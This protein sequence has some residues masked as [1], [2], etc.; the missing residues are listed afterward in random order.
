M[1]KS[2]SSVFTTTSDVSVPKERVPVGKG[3]IES[4]YYPAKVEYAYL[5]ESSAG[6]VGVVVSLKLDVQGT[7]VTKSETFW[8]TNR[9]KENFYKDKEGKKVVMPSFQT[10]TDIYGLVNNT[11]IEN[12]EADIDS[13]VIKVYDYDSKTEVPT[14]V[15]MITTLLNADIG[16]LMQKVTKNKSAKQANGSYADTA[17]F[18]TTNQI[19]KFVDKDSGMTLTEV[20]AGSPEATYKTAWLKQNEGVT[21]DLRTIKEAGT[22]L[23]SSNNASSTAVAPKKSLFSK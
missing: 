18:Y 7:E 2:L 9:N 13:R 19:A 5:T 1:S 17:E 16:V 22:T 14:E 3:A 15:N 8:I 6:A 20:I 4:G 11:P 12:I 10:I 23:S 21:R